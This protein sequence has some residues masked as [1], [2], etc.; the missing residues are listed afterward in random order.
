MEGQ[1]L[2]V[3]TFIENETDDLHCLQSCV[4]MV[5]NSAE[6]AA[7]SL[8]ESEAFTGFVLGQQT[9]PFDTLLSFAE[10]GYHVKNIEIIDNAH[11]ANDAKEAVTKEFGEDLWVH[12]NKVSDVKRAQASA[13]L[14]LEAS[15]IEMIKKI[16]NITDLSE[17]LSDNYFII[18]NVNAKTLDG[19]EGY[20]GHFVIVE[21]I[22]FLSESVEL[23]NPG[24]PPKKNQRIKL[25]RF[26]D[27]WNFPS[28]RA[29]NIMAFKKY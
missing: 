6:H 13:K 18:C 26:L 10:R 27:A 12:F 14:C 23:Q 29:A 20:N 2:K 3:K 17:L 16:P 11:F 25:S 5:V 9:W 1:N 8:E 4:R 28:E 21:H 15:N 22:D 24:L 19:L 7:M